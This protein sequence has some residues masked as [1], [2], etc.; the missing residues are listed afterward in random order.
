MR[1][2]KLIKI[3]LEAFFKNMKDIKDKK[4]LD[5]SLE[6]IRKEEKFKQIVN[7]DSSNIIATDEIN[8]EKQ[9]QDYLNNLNDLSK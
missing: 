7:Q 5:L 6:F 4:Y 2:N 1:T 9:M 3:V 8:R